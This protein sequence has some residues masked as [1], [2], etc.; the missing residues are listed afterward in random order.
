MQTYLFYDI[1]TTGLNKAFDQVLHFAAIRTD[2]NL[3][4]IKRYEFKIK[5]NPDC[6]PSPYAMIT[7]YIGIEET[8]QGI[9]E[10]DA[11]EQIHRILNEPGTI[12]LGYNT[13]GFDDEFLRFSFY[14]NLLPPYTHQ[15]ANQCGRM[16]LYPIAAMYFLYKKEVLNWPTLEGQPTLK[17]EHINTENQFVSGRSHHAMIDV[18]VTLALAKRFF[19]ARDM[20]DYVT[21][22]FNKRTDQERLQQLPVA[23]QGPYGSHREG[24]MLEGIFGAA[25]FYHCPVLFLGEHLH[26]KNQGLWLRLD[27]AQLGNTTADTIV[28]NTWVVRKKWGEPGFVLPPKERFLSH[29]SSERQALL[30]HNKNWLQQHP[31]LFQ[32]IIDYHRNYTYPVVPNADID[33]SLYINGFWSNEDNQL[34]NRFH[35]VGTAEKTKLVTTIRNPK[36]QSLA[37]RVLGRHYPDALTEEQKQQFTEY[38]QQVNAQDEAETIIDFKGGKRLTPKVAL[39]DISNLRQQALNEEQRKLLDGLE[40]YLLHQ[41]ASIVA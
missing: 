31:E 30:E 14:R 27:T 36:L 11:I 18:E 39:N 12:S 13:L 40:N 24:I 32:Q 5:L 16:D 25:Q 26:Y 34:C 38:M 29:L 41:F 28:E 23:L 33:S 10:L 4:E 9:S 3:D 35:Q 19:A 2:M 1:E 6:I 7:H 17:L 15:F 22:Y 21:S 20:W 8:Q 37:T